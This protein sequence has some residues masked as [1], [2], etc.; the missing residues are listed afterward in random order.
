MHTRTRKS[1]KGRQRSDSDS[2]SL[3]FAARP[4]TITPA[5]TRMHLVVSQDLAS[6]NSSCSPRA[7][8]TFSGNV[9][10]RSVEM[11]SDSCLAETTVAGPSIYR[12]NHGTIADHRRRA[13]TLNTSRFNK[14]LSMSYN[15]F[16]L[17][18]RRRTILQ[19]ANPTQAP[20]SA[21][22]PTTRS[23]QDRQF[24]PLL[25][26]HPFNRRGRFHLTWP[27][28]PFSGG[29]SSKTGRSEA[30]SHPLSTTTH[31]VSNRREG[32]P[33]ARIRVLVP[34]RAELRQLQVLQYR[35]PLGAATMDKSWGGVL[36]ASGS[37]DPML[38]KVRSPSYN[39]M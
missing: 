14:A 38:D 7:L 1:E 4:R 36:P 5:S 33:L 23:G 12:S 32:P 39:T 22:N 18:S 2:Y 21:P 37:G 3:C 17:G 31:N 24:S 35:G 8:T 29:P 26:R 10:F 11:L 6:P 20:P 25:Q 28:L 19:P 9:A 15:F 27:P 13:T 30:L 16:K 34:D